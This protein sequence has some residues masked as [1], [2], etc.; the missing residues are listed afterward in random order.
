[1]AGQ[2]PC[3]SAEPCITQSIPLRDVVRSLLVREDDI[4]GARFRRY[5]D[6]AKDVYRELNLYCI[7]WSKRYLVEVDPRDHSIRLPEDCLLVSSISIVDDCGRIEPLILNKNITGDIADI[8][9]HKSCGCKCNCNSELCGQLKNYE[10]I[11]TDVVAPMP[12]GTTQSFHVWARKAIYPD[13]SFY[14]EWQQPV[15]I[16]GE[17]GVHTATEVQ[18]FQEFICK[19]QTESCGC[20]KDCPDNR[21]IISGCC[22]DQFLY[23]EC[24]NDRCPPQY[25]NSYGYTQLGC[26]IFFP[27][28]F[29][30]DTVLLRYLP[31][32]TQGNFEVPLLAKKA[33]IAG[34][35][36]YSLPYDFDTGSGYRALAKQRQHALFF[37][38]WRDEKK[39][40]FRLLNRFSL[41]QFY[42]T[43]LPPGRISG[44]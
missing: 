42:M 22:G 3:S 33:M 14:R 19:L 15:Q 18:I 16:T 32:P 35:K 25:P 11:Y 36:V 40:L 34:I 6:I 39:A 10:V 2:V 24:C 28:D 4:L 44:C 12:D 7:R 23:T 26:K 17:G 9:L 1:M 31:E 5:Y 8:H 21:K 30:Y 38:Q 41:K 27:S 20:I 43:I 37:Q 29:P 13:G